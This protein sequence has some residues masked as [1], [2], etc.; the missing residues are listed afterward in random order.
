METFDFSQF[1]V[2]AIEKGVAIKKLQMF[3]PQ[4]WDDI[5]VQDGDS[6]IYVLGEAEFDVPLYVVLV[7]VHRPTSKN[8]LT[9]FTVTEQQQM[10]TEVSNLI[11]HE[12]TNIVAAVNN[13]MKNP[14]TGNIW[15]GV[16]GW[17]CVILLQNSQCICSCR[18]DACC[19]TPPLLPSQMFPVRTWNTQYS[20]R[21][22]FLQERSLHQWCTSMDA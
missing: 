4:R 21:H 3:K 17:K 12:Y 18:S 22:K 10:T 6:H 16:L 20:A 19:T 1:D 7:T 9:L 14:H 2:V 15:N 5:T 8:Y 13:Y 11:R